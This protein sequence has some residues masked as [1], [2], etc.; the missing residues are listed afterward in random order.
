MIGSILF[1][2][3]KIGDID[4]VPSMNDQRKSKIWKSKVRLMIGLDWL[5]NQLYLHIFS[6][7]LGQFRRSS[8]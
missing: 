5:E 8:A 6:A 3:T 1:F 2:W 4:D 7:L